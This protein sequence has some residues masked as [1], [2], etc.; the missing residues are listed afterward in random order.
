MKKPHQE[1]LEAV[2]DGLDVLLAQ[3]VY[4]GESDPGSVAG[5]LDAE[6]TAGVREVN[7]QR[8]D[9]RLLKKLQEALSTAE[10]TLGNTLQK[11][12]RKDGR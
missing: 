2:L 8:A 9:Q 11:C 4:P 1:T 3:E 7:D 5:V 10:I 6:G 12:T